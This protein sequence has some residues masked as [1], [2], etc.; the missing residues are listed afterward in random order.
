MPHAKR[1][2]RVE[3]IALGVLLLVY[4]LLVVFQ[5]RHHRHETFDER[6]FLDVGRQIV[7]TGLP[8]RTYRAPAP[9]L[10]F[11]HTPLY[12]YWVAAVTLLGGATLEL[13]RLTTLMFGVLSLVGVYWVGRVLRGPV[14]GLMGVAVLATNPFYATMS[15]FVHMEIPLCCVLVFALLAMARRHWLLAGL[16]L[17]VAVLLKE[18]ALGFL[19]VAAVYVLA[20]DGWLASILVGLP[21]AL[22]IGAWFAYAAAIGNSQLLAVFHRWY[23]SAAGGDIPDPRMHVRLRTWAQTVVHDIISP[24]GI[25]ATGAAAALAALDRR[26][27]PRIVLVPIGYIVL[28]ILTSFFIKLKEP[29]YVIA[30]IPMLAVTLALLVDW[31]GFARRIRGSGKA[32]IVT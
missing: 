16:L 25:L 4:L 7:Q 15:W 22:G 19:A 27:I 23:L 30:V 9:V 17:A 20:M 31:D 29:R 11:D 1:L 18:I 12:V 14:A 21:S 13:V 6:L 28:A 24:T 3:V 32:A 10:F 26:S 5:L 2:D 8:Y